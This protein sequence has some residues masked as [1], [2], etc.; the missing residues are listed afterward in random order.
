MDANTAV[1]LDLDRLGI[2]YQLHRH[3]GQLRS[4][5]Q[6]ARERG[7]TPDQIIRSLVFRL[8]DGS[9]VMVLMAGEAKVA[10]PKLRRFLGVSRLTTAAADEVRLVT[11]YEPGAV[12][13]YGLPE[14]LRILA[15]EHLLNLEIVSIGAGIR[16]AGIILRREDLI[17][18]THPEIGD[19]REAHEGKPGSSPK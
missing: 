11:G 15:D 9:F 12:S 5:A 1:T 3:P 10:W 19:F 17:E 18:S 13:P 2:P 6:A 8:E 7:L 4:L 14:P 16:N